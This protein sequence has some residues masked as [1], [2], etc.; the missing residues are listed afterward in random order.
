MTL[1]TIDFLQCYFVNHPSTI[2]FMFD[3]VDEV[4]AE[5]KKSAEVTHNHP[6]G[7]CFNKEIN[8]K[9]HSYEARGLSG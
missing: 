5:A 2:G 6:V 1:F 9:L 8:Y 3:T 4:L 7:K